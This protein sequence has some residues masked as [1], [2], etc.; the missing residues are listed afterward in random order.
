[1]TDASGTSTANCDKVPADL[2]E[3]IDQARAALGDSPLDLR[4]GERDIESSTGA[5]SRWP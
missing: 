5:V 1:M 2:A 3:Q 4:R